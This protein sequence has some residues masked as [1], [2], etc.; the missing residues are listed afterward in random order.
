MNVDFPEPDGPMTATISPASDLDRDAPQRVHRVVAEGVVL[1]EP[2][3][4]DQRN[5]SSSS[6][7]RPQWSQR[8]AGQ[9]V[10][11]ASSSPEAAW[12]SPPQGQGSGYSSRHSGHLRVA[13]DVRR[14]VADHEQLRHGARLPHRQTSTGILLWVSTLT[15]SLPSTRADMPFRPWEAMKIR[16]QPPLRAVSMIAS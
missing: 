7:E 16:S 9:S 11:P 8:V 1:R 4:R 6:S 2:L 3:G 14:L 5:Q 10:P 15:V 12:I 13:H